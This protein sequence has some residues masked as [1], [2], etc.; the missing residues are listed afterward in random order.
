MSM[1]TAAIVLV[2]DQTLAMVSRCQGA[3]SGP[4]SPAQRSTTGAPST[5]TATDAP[6]SSPSRKFC[7]KRSRT[8]WNASA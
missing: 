3:P 2:D 6:A 5:V 4:A 1:Q 8:G 7:S